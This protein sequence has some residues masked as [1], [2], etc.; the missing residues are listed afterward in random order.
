[1]TKKRVNVY[2]DGFNLYYGA[3]RDNPDLKWLNI[4]RWC[5]NILPGYEVAK[6][7]YFTA[8]VVGRV[9]DPD[10]PT[11]QDHYFKA[12]RTLSGLDL[13]FG[14]FKVR[15]K[16][17]KR[18]ENDRC[19]CCA[20]HDDTQ[21]PQ[22]KCCRKVTVEV[23]KT[24]EKGSDVNLALS[25]VKD[26]FTSNIDSILIVSGD[27]DLAMAARI[28]KEQGIE[29]IIADPGGQNALRGDRR[30]TVRESA[31]RAC[32]FPDEVMMGD[33]TTVNRPDAWT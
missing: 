12:L 29:V 22:C 6:I 3:L 28:A 24:E 20:T 14:K 9:E 27:A 30:I 32:Q 15:R 18:V 5:E 26:S 19:D 2:I 23:E 1:M 13:T 4:R 25:I 21:V 7:G 8:K 11:R 31:M 16:R 10:A 33:G 17:L